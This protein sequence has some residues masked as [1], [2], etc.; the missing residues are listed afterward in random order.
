M[1]KVDFARFVI[2]VEKSQAPGN[3]CFIPI[4]KTETDE[5]GL[6]NQMATWGEKPLVAD[7][8]IIGY[9]WEGSAIELE[10]WQEMQSPW[11]DKLNIQTK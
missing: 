6:V 1:L 11:L 3:I 5:D 2:D 4:T 8:V 7:A 10:Q 9:V